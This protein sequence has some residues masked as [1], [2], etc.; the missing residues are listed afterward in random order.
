MLN[1]SLPCEEPPEINRDCATRVRLAEADTNYKLRL[2]LSWV[3]QSAF[4]FFIL[5]FHIPPPPCLHPR[6]YRTF[7]LIEGI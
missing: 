2:A 3:F 6:K 7:P 4:F 1:I 5:P